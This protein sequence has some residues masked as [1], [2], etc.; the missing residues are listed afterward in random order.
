[1]IIVIP[2]KNV[3]GFRAHYTKKKFTKYVSLPL[4]FK[5]LQ[6]LFPNP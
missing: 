6:L 1:M 3:I 4:A 2:L 5:A